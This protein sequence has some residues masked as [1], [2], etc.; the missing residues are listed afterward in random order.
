MYRIAW[1]I[2]SAVLPS[3]AR[4]ILWR[5]S[6]SHA[7]N[8][9]HCLLLRACLLILPTSLIRSI[10]IC[11]Y[12]LDVDSAKISK[13]S[14]GCVV[15]SRLFWRWSPC[16]NRLRRVWMLSKA[17]LCLSRDSQSTSVISEGCISAHQYGNRQAVIRLA[18]RPQALP[19]TSCT[20]GPFSPIFHIAAVQMYFTPLKFFETPSHVFQCFAFWLS[21]K[22]L[23]I[24]YYTILI[25]WP[26]SPYLEW[27]TVVNRAFCTR[28]KVC[29][30]V[31]CSLLTA[32]ITKPDV[33]NAHWWRSITSTST[34]LFWVDF[35]KKIF[36]HM[37]YACGFRAINI[38]K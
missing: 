17:E 36:E 9:H 8:N 18:I 3:E 5:V 20:L 19:V 21:K 15:Y 34:G 6:F 29:V 14:Q 16:S 25:G 28:S 4:Y 11:S 37:F 1:T 30:C 7:L 35:L 10:C 13:L 12:V 33:F 31:C 23:V 32:L 27:Y 38:K 2:L 22:L 24:T 26:S